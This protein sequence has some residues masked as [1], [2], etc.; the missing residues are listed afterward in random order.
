LHDVESAP[1]R[2]ELRH[3]QHAEGG[4]KPTRHR[5]RARPSAMQR[6]SRPRLRHRKPTT[7]TAVRCAGLSFT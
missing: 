2:R 6:R 7:S 4:R 5:P 3:E 1:Q